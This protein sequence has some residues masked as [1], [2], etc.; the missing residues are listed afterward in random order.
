[1][2]RLNGCVRN[3]DLI[4]RKFSYAGGKYQDLEYRME[5][6]VCRLCVLFLGGKGLESGGGWREW[7]GLEIF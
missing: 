3:G 1:M 6:V 5:I 4:L 2:I 7:R